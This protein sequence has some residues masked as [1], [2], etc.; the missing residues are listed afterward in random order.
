MQVKST[1]EAERQMQYYDRKAKAISLETGDL[2]LTKVDA[3][4]GKR[5]VKDRWEEELHEV[6]HQVAEGVPSYL[7]KNQQTGHSQVL[8]QK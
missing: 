4:R 5:K 2:V 6:E 1:S 3:H 8:H 7:M